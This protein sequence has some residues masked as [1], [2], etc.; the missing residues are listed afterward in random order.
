M[1]FERCR[2]RASDIGPGLV[3]PLVR[4]VVRRTWA[5]QTTFCRGWSTSPWGT[6]WQRRQHPLPRRIGR[7]SAAVVLPADLIRVDNF[8]AVPS[9]GATVVCLDGY[10][11]YNRW[12]HWPI[13]T[14][15][16]SHKSRESATQYR[17]GQ[18][19]RSNHKGITVLF[20]TKSRRCVKAFCNHAITSQQSQ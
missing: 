11:L 8:G 2:L 4:P 13:G 12:H 5:L 6:Y 15:G 3:E 18:Q 14:V 16:K 10:L 19:H 1:I 17:T 9:R 20:W 7:V